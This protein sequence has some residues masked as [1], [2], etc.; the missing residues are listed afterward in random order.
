MKKYL[1]V[2]LCG[3]TIL[4]LFTACRKEPETYSSWYSYIEVEDEADDEAESDATSSNNRIV[5]NSTIQTPK[6]MTLYKGGMQTSVED[7]TLRLK[8]AKEIEKLFYD[9]NSNNLPVAD[10]EVTRKFIWETRLNETVIELEFDI[11]YYDKLNIL[12]KIELEK[13][14]RILIPL[15]GEYAYYLF[16]GTHS[17]EYQN[18]PFKLNGSGLEKIFEGVTLDKK[19]R[20]WESTV[21]APTTVTFYKDGATAVSTD[22]ELNL[23]I[24]QTIESWFMYRESLVACKCA[25]D[26]DNFIPIKNKETAIELL[27][28]SE[29]NFNSAFSSQTYSIFIPLT[30]EKANQAFHLSFN[31]PYSWSSP[32]GVDASILEPYFQYVELTPLPEEEKKWL[33]TVIPSYSFSAYEKRKKVG[34]SEKHYTDYLLNHKIMQ[35]I[36]S[37]FYKKEEI[38]RVDLGFTD[39]RL[40]E[41]KSTSKYLEIKLKSNDY[42][43]FG[44]TIFAE[45]T[46]YI[47]IPLDGD[48]AY[49]IF[50][51]DENKNYSYNAI[52]TEGS[53]LEEYSEKIKTASQTQE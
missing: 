7:K 12:G 44:K 4:S 16:S 53:G 31:H 25:G 2:L 51:G 32:I 30:G 36:E 20:D 23:K 26:I 11:G 1:A 6:Y 50:E 15:T 43:F 39:T 45:N 17:G 13:S 48:Y 46:K 52:V 42:L 10:M 41:V 37:W 18:K 47:V 24:A 8:A 35:K 34:E 21:I 49:Y 29:A 38:N 40:N 27:F 5:Y 3:L 28:E 19:V 33:S 22:K 14:K 9:Y